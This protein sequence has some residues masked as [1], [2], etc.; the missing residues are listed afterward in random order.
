MDRSSL[1]KHSCGIFA[2]VIVLCLFLIV[3]ILT[4]PVEESHIEFAFKMHK[5]T[6][7]LL[8]VALSCITVLRCTNS[9]KKVDELRRLD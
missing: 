9:V 5:G 2:F 1:R 6:M 3:S 4:H 8:F 7:W